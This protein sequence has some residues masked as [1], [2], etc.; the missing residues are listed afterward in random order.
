MVQI[1]IV[2][3]QEEPAAIAPDNRYWAA[4]LRA[5]GEPH[6]LPWSESPGDWAFWAAEFD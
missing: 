6:W 1:G 5:G 4:I 3:I 2:S